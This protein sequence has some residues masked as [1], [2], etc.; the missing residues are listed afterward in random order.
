MALPNRPQMQRLKW[1]LTASQVEALDDMLEQLFKVQKRPTGVTLPEDTLGGRGPSSGSGSIEPITL[2]A[3]LSIVGSELQV[4]S[5]LEPQML[6]RTIA[7]TIDGAGSTITTGVK[8]YLRLPVAVTLTGWTILGDQSGAIVIDVWADTYANF[9]PTNTDSITNGNEP[10]IAAS[11]V[12][13]EDTDLSNWTDVTMPAGTVLGFNVDSVT[14][15]TRVILQITC[16][17]DI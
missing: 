8:G 11:G 13:A 14:A 16:T 4:E 1:P 12:K 6:T 5:E 17:V 9:P 15:F 7:L 2:G 10:T 3:R